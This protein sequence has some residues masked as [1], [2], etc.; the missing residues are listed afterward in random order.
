MNKNRYVNY[1]NPNINENIDVKSIAK[2]NSKDL[3]L[4]KLEIDE[5]MSLWDSNSHLDTNDL[6]SNK[7]VVKSENVS[8]ESFNN[9]KLYDIDHVTAGVISLPPEN[10]INYSNH[11]IK[12][13]W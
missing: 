10:W 5:D 12:H 3:Y 7:S 2:S 13:N 9:G 6:F 4:M 1:I 8:Y 11:M